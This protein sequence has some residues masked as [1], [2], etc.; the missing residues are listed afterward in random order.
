MTYFESFD[1]FFREMLGDLGKLDSFTEGVAVPWALYILF[2][3]ASLVLF[4]AMLNVLIS[5]IGVTFSKVKDNEHMTKNWEKWNIITEIDIMRSEQEKN[6]KEKEYLMVMYNDREKNEDDLQEIK[7]KVEKLET[8][9]ES[10]QKVQEEMK[11]L[12]QEKSIGLEIMFHKILENQEKTLK[13]FGDHA[14][15]ISLVKSSYR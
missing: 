14:K 1:I 9:M 8:S 11:K 10:I 2:V 15:E 3:V 12:Q 13:L 5:I 6:K 4:I 7:S